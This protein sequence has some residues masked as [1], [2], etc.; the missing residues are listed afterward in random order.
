MPWY[1]LIALV[2]VIEVITLELINVH[3]TIWHT[4]VLCSPG[5]VV[6]SHFGLSVPPRSISKIGKITCKVHK[7]RI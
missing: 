7:N 2:D 4:P 5:P 6:E 3:S 1:V